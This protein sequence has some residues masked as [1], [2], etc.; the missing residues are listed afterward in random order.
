MKCLPNFTT[1]FFLKKNVIISPLCARWHYGDLLRLPLTPGS[2]TAA[3][4]VQ[5]SKWEW[6]EAKVR[7]VNVVLTWGSCKQDG[8][9]VDAHSE[10]VEDRESSEAIGDRVSLRKSMWSSKKYIWSSILIQFWDTFITLYTPLQVYIV[11]SALILPHVE[12]I[13]PFQIRHIIYI[14]ETFV[15]IPC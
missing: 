3:V 12:V 7:R 14:Q 10:C 13:L 11:L 8:E 4:L 5:C 1:Y 2:S 15:K 9:E 6:R